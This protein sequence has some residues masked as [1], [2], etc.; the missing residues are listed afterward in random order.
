MPGERKV[1]THETVSSFRK[2]TRASDRKFGITIGLILLALSLWPLLR[3]SSGPN[4]WFLVPAVGLLLATWLKPDWLAP[5]NRAWFGLGLALNAVV[6]PVV[7]GAL[8][9][10]AVTPMGLYLR[11]TG[12]DLLQLARDPEA[13]TYWNLREPPGPQPGTFNKQF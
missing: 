6:G 9:F 13:E 2:I 4:L 12:K 3:G 11:R 7:M 8:F 10:G 1:G 5:L